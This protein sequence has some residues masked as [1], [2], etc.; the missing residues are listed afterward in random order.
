MNRVVIPP[1]PVYK[2][3]KD[4]IHGQ[5]PVTRREFAILQLPVFN[6]LH[7][8]KQLAMAFLVYPGAQASRF[9]HSLGAMHLASMMAYQLLQTMDRRTFHTLFPGASSDASRLA[10][11]QTIRLGALLHDVGHGP[12]SHAT[13][14]I[15]RGAMERGHR[16]ELK[17]ALGL[18][19]SKELSEFPVHEYYSFRLIMDGELK[20]TINSKVLGKSNAGPNVQVDARD[21]GSLLLKKTIANSGFATPDGVRILRKIISSQLDADRMDYLVRD[22]YMTGVPYGI[23]DVQ[24][25][26]SQMCVRPDRFG[27]Y[28]LAVHERAIGSV[29]DFLDAR[30]KM[31]KWL[32]SH[33]M[34]VALNELLKQAIV[35]LIE[36][37][38]LSAATF[39]WRSF[40]GGQV[41]DTF[42]M[43]RL[44]RET[45]S[46]KSPFRG[47]LDR[48]YLPLS[49]LKR[50]RD[51][52]EFEEA[53][54]RALGRDISPEAFHKKL[55]AVVDSLRSNPI[56]RI[57]QSTVRML[58]V[59]V[60]RSPYRAFRGHDTVYFCSDQVEKLEELTEVSEY[61]V[62]INREWI[63][64]P[65]YYL[66][67]VRAGWT[68]KATSSIANKVRAK[69]IELIA[70]AS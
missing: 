56:L 53:I 7:D 11:V 69:L 39:H 50:P 35:A 54:S 33:H 58:A 19:A 44:L 30:F 60:P 52:W 6:R 47:L 57:G 9:A 14:E 37:R 15:M 17:Q 1:L 63:E 48:R 29:E 25:V 41:S 38:Q 24:R 3:V 43:E 68:K 28:E 22:A 70:T 32:V 4:P 59:P 45:K 51:H 42:V 46:K 26:I 49:L 62:G 64:F 67:F 31:Y 13:E 65:S 12:F 5:I 2:I 55:E 8:I 21:V 23:V 61:F 40:V 18:F 36:K 20:R 16:A 66:S 27:N 34:V 10:L